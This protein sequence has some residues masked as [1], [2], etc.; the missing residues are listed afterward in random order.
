MLAFPSITICPMPMDD[1]LSDSGFNLTKHIEES[2]L[3]IEETVQSLKHH[4]VE[5]GNGQVL[6]DQFNAVVQRLGVI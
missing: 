1:L 4:Y 6:C 3:S 5:D 2:A